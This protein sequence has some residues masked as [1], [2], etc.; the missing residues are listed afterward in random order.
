MKKNRGRFRVIL[1]DN[2]REND[3]VFSVV[4][5]FRLTGMKSV[6][7]YHGLGEALLHDGMHTV[8]LVCIDVEAFIK[9]ADR[10]RVSV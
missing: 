1:F 6:Y 5:I 2:V 7:R 8:R 3:P 4:Y 10:N 9:R